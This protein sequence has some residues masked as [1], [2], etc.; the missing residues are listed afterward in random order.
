M[1]VVHPRVSHQRKYSPYNL[2]FSAVEYAISR[3]NDEDRKTNLYIG[4]PL[5]FRLGEVNLKLV[6]WIEDLQNRIILVFPEF[7]VGFGVEEDY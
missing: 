7:T 1:S 3:N 4:V 6:L 5:R 2:T